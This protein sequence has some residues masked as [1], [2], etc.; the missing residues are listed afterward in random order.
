RPTTL[1]PQTDD[2]IWY[3]LYFQEPGVAEAEYDR[4][5][6]AVFHAGKISISGGRAAGHAALR[7]GAAARQTLPLGCARPAVAAVA[8]RS[9]CR[10]LHGGIHP[11][12]VSRRVQL[13]SQYRSQL[14]IA[15][16]V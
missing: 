11:H 16:A 9:R 13:V 12:R 3:Q 4:N 14:G 8:D 5:V 10:F 15:G 2:A 1:M 6:R 7:H